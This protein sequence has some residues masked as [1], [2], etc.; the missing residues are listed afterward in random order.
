MNRNSNADLIEIAMFSSAIS[1]EWNDSPRNNR[2]ATRLYCRSP[3]SY[4]AVCNEA[5]SQVFLT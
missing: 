2:D 4:F 3:L 5:D 1:P